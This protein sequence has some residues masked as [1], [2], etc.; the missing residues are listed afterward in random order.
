MKRSYKGFSLIELMIVIAIIGVLAAVAMPQYGN[1]IRKSR[2]AEATSNINSIALYQEQYFSENNQYL[3]LTVNPENI[4]SSAVD[5]GTLPF[6]ATNVTWIEL[7]SIMPPNTPVR[8]QYE[9]R[10]GQFAE[11]PATDISGFPEVAFSYS[12][13]TDCTPGTQAYTPVEFLT[14]APFA[15]WFVIVA[16]GNQRDTPAGVCS[17]FVKSSGQTNTIAINEIE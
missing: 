16:V 9:A 4:P 5:G 6:D 11:D 17:V 7:G 8:F 12:D 3:N 15:H 1:Y 10:A 2:T 13:N 14:P